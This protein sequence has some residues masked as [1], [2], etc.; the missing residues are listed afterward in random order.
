MADCPHLSRTQNAAGEIIPAAASSRL[1]LTW[2]KEGKVHIA[3]SHLEDPKTGEFNLSFIRKEFPDKDFSMITFAHWEEGLVVAPG[4]PKNI[5]KIE[6]RVL[7]KMLEAEALQKQVQDAAARLEGEKGRVDTEKNR[8]ESVR[9]AAD[10]DRA[11]L[12]ARRRVLAEGLSEPVRETY[13]RVRAGRHGVA[14]AEVRDGFCGGCHVRLRPQMYN[15][16]RANAS[17]LTCESCS[18]IL[19]YV[20]PAPEDA[21][22]AGGQGNRAAAPN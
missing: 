22:A 14:V 8:L 18:R 16:V 15:D 1:A 20:E 9:R 2:L 13:E 17:I 12:L 4:N 11:Q 21:D 6:D 10:E 3:G 5:R 19:Y 7:E